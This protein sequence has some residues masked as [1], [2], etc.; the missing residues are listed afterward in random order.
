M[1]CKAHLDQLLESYSWV[2]TMPDLPHPV[3]PLYEDES[4]IWVELHE[5]RP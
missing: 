4:N 1:Q 5:A 3:E 2:D